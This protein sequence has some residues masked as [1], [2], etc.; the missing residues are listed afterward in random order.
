MRLRIFI[1]C[2]AVGCK[3]FDAGKYAPPTGDPPGSGGYDDT[4]TADPADVLDCE[5]QPLLNWTNFGQ[6]FLIQYCNGCHHSDTP[7]RYG[8]PDEAVFDSVDLVWD[9]KGSI[10]SVSTGESPRMPPNGGASDLDRRML[11]IWLNCGEPGT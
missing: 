11:E 1:L 8:A 3:S 9:Q 10:L 6:G 4:G 2:A 7:D 5:D